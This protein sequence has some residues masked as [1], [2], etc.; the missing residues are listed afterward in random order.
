MFGISSLTPL[1]VS[2]AMAVFSALLYYFGRL[3]ADTHVEQAD[4]PTL[5]VT[6]FIFIVFFVLIPGIVV[7][8]V[9]GYLQWIPDFALILLQILMFSM[10]SWALKTY[11]YFIKHGLS[12]VFQKTY[13]KKLEEIKNENNFLGRL[14]SAYGVSKDPVSTFSSI[15]ESNR[16][17]SSNYAFLMLVSATS[18]LAIYRAISEAS[19]LL[20]AI[21]SI[22]GFFLFT[23]TALIYG[24]S[25]AYYPP[26]VIYLKDGQILRGKLLKFGDFVYLLDQE[27]KVK[28]FINKQ[29]IQVL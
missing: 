12:E 14:I 17:I 25:T 7:Y 27:R 3:I 11:E 10:I 9:K 18:L 16:R 15:L 4:K 5:Y 19:L 8:Y 6:G 29:E 1:N 24:F 2:I 20:I 21:T 23:M 28:I 22:L 26:A 13:R